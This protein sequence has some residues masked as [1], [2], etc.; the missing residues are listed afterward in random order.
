MFRPKRFGA[1][2]TGLMLIVAA[3]GGDDPASTT[4]GSPVTT[5]VPTTSATTLPP[6]DPS[7]AGGE[8]RSGEL[9]GGWEV[10]H[11]ALPDGALTNVVGEEAVFI[12]FNADGTIRYH[13]GCNSGG[14]QF[15]TS[16][17][18]YIPESALDDEPEG[19]AITLGPVFEQTEIG[20]EGFLGDQ[21]VDLPANMGAVTRFIVDDDRLLL[22]DEFLL[23]DA[24]R[25]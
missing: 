24:T 20:C 7:P 23:I 10:S 8:D 1:L 11:Y 14:S 2:V 3:C 25:G 13:T 18:Y 5:A 9:L 22:L 19:Q 17:S 12:E 21:D 6:E 16:G 15:E 4:A